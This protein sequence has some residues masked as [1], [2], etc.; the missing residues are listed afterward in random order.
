VRSSKAIPRRAYAPMTESAGEACGTGIA[1]A[2]IQQGAQGDAKID[3]AGLQRGGS[4]HVAGRYV[5]EHDDAG[6]TLGT[7]GRRFRR[8]FPCDRLFDQPQT[9][10][11]V[12]DQT[13]EVGN[14][15]A[16]CGI[17][18]V[19]CATPSPAAFCMAALLSYFFRGALLLVR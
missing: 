15:G 10:L 19:A 5:V 18:V 2:G 4:L 3:V 17:L 1:V 7:A 13:D 11:N 16:V 8:S 12:L 6:G 9:V 14:H